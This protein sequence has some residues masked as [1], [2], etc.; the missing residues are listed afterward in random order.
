MERAG[1]RLPL[2]MSPFMVA[3]VLK[4]HQNSFQWSAG[5]KGT[6]FPSYSS[7]LAVSAFKPAFSSPDR[8][9]SLN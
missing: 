9:A 7:L 6:C 1:S 8:G 4:R 2:V 3:F 5:L